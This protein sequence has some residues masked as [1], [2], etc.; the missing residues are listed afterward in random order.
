[1]INKSAI[2]KIIKTLR[3]DK[4]LTQ[5]ELAEKIEISKNYLSKVERGLSTLNAESFLKMAA[6][7]EFNLED[8]GIKF[9]NNAIKDDS[10][11]EL[12]NLILSS[13]PNETQ[14]YLEVVKVLNKFI[15]K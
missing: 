2:G 14:A 12:I 13:S 4:K 9:Q 7:L 3:M 5:E 1:M 6:V 15:V 11:K 8:F 10:K